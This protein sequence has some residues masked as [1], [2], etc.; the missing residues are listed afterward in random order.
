VIRDE[1]PATQPLDLTQLE[2][3]L[4]P[5]LAGFVVIEG[6]GLGSTHILEDGKHIIGRTPDAYI[7]IDNDLV[8]RSHAEIRFEEGTPPRCFL[9]DLGSTNGTFVNDVPITEV[10]LTSGDTVRIGNHLLKYLYSDEQDIR[11]YTKVH[12]LIRYD[13]LTGLLSRSCFFEELSREMQKADKRHRPLSVLMI[14]IDRFKRVNDTHGHQTGSAVLAQLGEVFR[15]FCRGKDI[16]GRYGGEEFLIFLTKA[17][18]K[19]AFTFAE[20][21]RKRIEAFDFEYGTIRPKITVSIGVAT[22]PEHG[23]ELELLVRKSDAALYFAK[24]SGRNRTCVFDPSMLG[25]SGEQ[26]VMPRDGDTE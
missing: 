26:I 6:V 21:L 7:H 12:G 8:S 5:K 16:V 14:D 3:R 13:E 2:R 25:A 11:F 9:R 22:M 15:K 10:E 4:R 18:K 20:Q 17:D 19:Q 1:Q 23:A 24:S